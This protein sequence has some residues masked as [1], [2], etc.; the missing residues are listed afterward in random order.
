[1][2]GSGLFE[3]RPPFKQQ[4]V[5]SVVG[6][7]GTFTLKHIVIFC[8][9]LINT[10]LTP[11]QEGRGQWGLPRESRFDPGLCYLTWPRAVF[12]ACSLSVLVAAFSPFWNLLL[13]P[14]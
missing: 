4:E 6:I 1:M 14:L 11:V 10:C 2:G 5:A 3:V 12:S 13:I 9:G 7:K 8:L